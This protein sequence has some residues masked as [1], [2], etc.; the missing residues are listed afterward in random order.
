[1]N[2]AQNLR[3]HGSRDVTTSLLRTICPS[4]VGCYNQLDTKFEVS[5]FIHYEDVKAMQIVEIG[6]FSTGSLGHW[7]CHYSTEHIQLPIQLY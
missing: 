2:R 4:Y 1:M 6:W 7:Q 5:M 3:I